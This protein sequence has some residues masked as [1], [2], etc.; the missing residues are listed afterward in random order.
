MAIN[1]YSFSGQLEAERGK[2]GRR[3]RRR[4]ERDG[5]REREK[6]KGKEL[7]ES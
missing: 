2:E 3:E 4:K 1:F 7:A 5:C 6:L